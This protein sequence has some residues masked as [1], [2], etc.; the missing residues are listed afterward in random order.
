MEDFTPVRIKG[1]AMGEMRTKVVFTAGTRQNEEN[2]RRVRALK[3]GF[4]ERLQMVATLN[5]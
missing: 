3:Q 5:P 2:Q 1:H 4:E